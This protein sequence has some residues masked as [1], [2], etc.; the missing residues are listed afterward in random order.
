VRKLTIL[1]ALVAAMATL[2]GCASLGLASASHDARALSWKDVRTSHG[3]VIVADMPAPAP[4]GLASFCERFAETCDDA[5]AAPRTAQ[6]QPASW[7]QSA[8]PIMAW[9]PQPNE[10]GASMFSR[11]LQMRAQGLRFDY[12]RGRV[13]LSETLW[14]EL[15]QV[16]QQVNRSIAAATDSARYGMNE[17][18]TM[19]LTGARGGQPAQGDCEDY[20]LEK[21][22]R[23][24]AL[25]WDPAALALAVAYAPG[26]GNHAVLIAQTDRGDFVLD[27]LFD[28]PLPP[29]RLDYGWVSRQAGA[30]M[31]VWANA[32]IEAAPALGQ[33]PTVERPML[34]MLSLRAKGAS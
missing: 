19:P 34:A 13:E 6:M 26:V 18:W 17:Y 24:I 2:G 9:T 16:N 11:M 4:A 32:R 33:P 14:R 15:S 1:P 10:D 12:P 7:T 30:S 20:A 3:A 21:R 23:L 27:N 8:D 31:T 28:A 29:N 22:A 25:G 5:A